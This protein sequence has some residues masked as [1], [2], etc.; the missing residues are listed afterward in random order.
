ME[1]P[2]NPSSR[3]VEARIS[4]VPLYLY[5]VVMLDSM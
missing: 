1:G 2:D 3:I 4:K 5:L